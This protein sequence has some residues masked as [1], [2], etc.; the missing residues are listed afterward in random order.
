V[1][2]LWRIN[3]KTEDGK[4]KNERDHGNCTSNSELAIHENCRS[5]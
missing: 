4:R 3:K 1:P 2:T 5:T